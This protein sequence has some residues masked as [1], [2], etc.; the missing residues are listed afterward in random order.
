LDNLNTILEAKKTDL[1]Q[2]SDGLKGQIFNQ[3]TSQQEMFS[4]NENSFKIKFQEKVKN[5][6]D[7]FNRRIHEIEVKFIDKNISVVK[8]KVDAELE[9]M[10][11]FEDK[12]ISKEGEI[13]KKIDI[14][15]DLQ[16]HFQAEAKHQ[17]ESMHQKVE[18]RL[19]NLEKHFNKRF[20]DYDG[21]FSSLKSIIVEEVEDLIKEVNQVLTSQVDELKKHEAKLDFKKN[22]IQTIRDEF[23][24]IKNTILPHYTE[25]CKTVKDLKVQVFGQLEKQS[26]ISSLVYNM[27]S[28]ENQLIKLIS[29]LQEKG[30]SFY[31]IQNILLQKGHPR[32]YVTTLI[33]QLGYNQ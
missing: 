2:Y 27:S 5:L 8:E 7:L 31:E 30:L 16:N 29:D 6:E 14:L 17:S 3:L 11:I 23:Y 22:E 33:S 1:T 12:L 10:K 21:K 20:L 24:N 13:D 9:F 4:Q 18:E 28:Y 25:L 15:D 26:D 19:I 32:V